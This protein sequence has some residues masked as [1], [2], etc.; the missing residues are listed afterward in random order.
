MI[1][2]DVAWVRGNVARPPWVRVASISPL[3]AVP[4][5]GIINFVNVWLKVKNVVPFWPSCIVAWSMV[6]S[7]KGKGLVT[8]SS[9]LIYV[10]FA[11]ATS[12]AHR[13][14][15]FLKTIVGVINHS[16]NLGIITHVAEP[17]SNPITWEKEYSAFRY[18][19]EMKVQLHTNKPK[20]ISF[21]GNPRATNWPSISPTTSGLGSATTDPTRT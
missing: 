2:K 8:N 19:N 9:S 15:S 5:P 18:L 16:Y 13:W 14:C 11:K 10:T 3:F 21:T 12:Q 4:S 1:S 7:I 6:I 17:T 20:S